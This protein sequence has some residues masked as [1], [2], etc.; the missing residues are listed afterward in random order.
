M[1]AG[2][3][4]SDL[5][6][7]TS[8]V[9]RLGAERCHWKKRCI[10]REWKQYR[11]TVPHRQSCTAASRC[12]TDSHVQQRHGAAP[13]VMYSSVTVPHRQSCT[14]ASRCRTDS[15]V[16][17]RHGA[18]PTVMYSSVTARDSS[19]LYVKRCVSALFKH[20]Q[21]VMKALSVPGPL[22]WPLSTAALTGHRPR[23][24]KH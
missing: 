22:R 23:V 9:Q 5:D 17:Q 10:R 7:K 21:L 13:T 11:P 12:R 15:H 2:S 24:S 1:A 3:R 8:V 4:Q 18:A 6:I 19:I 20:R 14:A 16:Q